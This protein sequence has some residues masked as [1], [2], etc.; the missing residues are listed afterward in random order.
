[1]TGEDEQLE[2]LRRLLQVKGVPVPYAR[3]FRGWDKWDDNFDDSQSHLNCEH[4]VF[5]KSPLIK[6]KSNLDKSLSSFR[7]CSRAARKSISQAP[8]DNLLIAIQ[9]VQRTESAECLDD[10]DD[11]RCSDDPP[12]QFIEGGSLWRRSERL[13]GKGAFGDVWLGMSEDG[14]LVALK[15]L[16]V[17]LQARKR[18]RGQDKTSETITSVVNEVEMLSKYRDDSIVSFISCGVHDRHVIIVMEYVSGGSI[19]TVLETFGAIKPATAKRYTKDIIR[20]LNY[21]HGE[22]IVH[23]DLKPGNVLLHTDGQCKLSD[24]GTCTRITSMASGQEVCGTP[25][26]MAPEVCRGEPCKSSDLWALGLTV[27]QMLQNLTPFQWAPDVPET[28][29]QFM[30]WLGKLYPN[31]NVPIPD[32]DGVTLDSCAHSFVKRLLVCD[33]NKRGSASSLLFDPFVI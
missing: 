23:R 28:P 14:A 5:F 26:Y 17:P 30:R 6:R 21:L 1:M 25:L 11:N 4:A 22:G 27:I 15:V 31:D 13:L 9:E 33:K 10:S 20:G 18:F 19:S 3:S 2:R 32:S 12:T 24:F 7:R 8:G 29:F 16:K